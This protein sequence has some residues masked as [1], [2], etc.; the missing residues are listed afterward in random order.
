MN[1]GNDVYAEKEYSIQNNSPTVKRFRDQP[2]PSTYD[3][4][5]IFHVSKYLYMVGNNS[6]QKSNAMLKN[7]LRNGNYQMKEE[8]GTNKFRIREHFS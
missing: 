8:N 1:D 7:I 6:L 3:I 5:S 2:L 4:C